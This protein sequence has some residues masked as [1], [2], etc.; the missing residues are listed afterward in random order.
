LFAR[1][2]WRPRRGVEK[3]VTDVF[4]WVRAN[5]NELRPLV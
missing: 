5:E 1:T 3:I 2:A 4:E